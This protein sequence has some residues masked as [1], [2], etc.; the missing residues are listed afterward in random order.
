MLNKQSMTLHLLGA[1]RSPDELKISHRQANLSEVTS[2]SFR[3]LSSPCVRTLM[4]AWEIS[5]I[6]GT[7]H[8]T[9][10]CKT[11]L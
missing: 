10:S 1:E 4:V 11:V 9:S 7:Q 5:T 3:G 6:V 8:V 2:K